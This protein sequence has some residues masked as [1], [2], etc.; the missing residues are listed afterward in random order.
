[1]VRNTLY[2]INRAFTD[3]N[4]FKSAGIFRIV[5]GFFSENNFNII[6]ST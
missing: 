6:L 1:M 4:Q 5:F 2:L 3:K